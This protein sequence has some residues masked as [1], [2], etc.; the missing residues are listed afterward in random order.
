M[1][2]PKAVRMG[3]A[4][5][6]IL[7][8]TAALCVLGAAAGGATVAHAGEPAPARFPLADRG[9][10]NGLVGIP[11]GWT[12]LLQ[13]P[14]AELSWQITNNA[15]GERATGERLLLDGETHTVTLR[16][17]HP[18]GER[19]AIGVELPWIAHG[20]G[21]LDGSIDA[22]HDALGLS[23]GIRPLLPARDL[24]YVY[25]RAGQP[26][27]GAEDSTSGLGDLR[28]TL[29]WRLM[30]P[31]AQRP[32]LDLTADVEWATGDADRLTGNGGTDL[33][34]G[35]RAGRG[36]I[37]GTPGLGP[38]GWSAQAGLVWPGDADEPLPP[39][40]GQFWYYDTAL[41][42]AATSALDLVVQ[43][44][45]H[46]GA[47]QSHVTMLGDTALQLGLGAIWHPR[48][49]LGLRL[50]IFEDLR[51]DTTPD[52]AIEL[53]LTYRPGSGLAPGAL[54]AE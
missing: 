13:G 46:G 41:A 4:S 28:T 34:A 14:A 52:F 22:W 20:G 9:P 1:I 36:G 39:A 27:A 26:R 50:G 44:Q 2:V 5:S 21:F 49:R 37:A 25:D 19:L 47:W 24:R 17:Q 16:W 10:L 51:T 7:T 38:L 35:L 23:E 6:A 11:N 12:Q 8:A 32:A 45:G 42:W 3:P 40:A 48:P 18:L 30:T 53:A 29:A 43:L 33:A 15:M 54:D 31:G